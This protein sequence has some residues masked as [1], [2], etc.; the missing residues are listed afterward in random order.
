MRRVFLIAG[1][2]TAVA[3]ATPARAFVQSTS[4][5]GAGLHWPGNCLGVYYNERGSDDIN[6]DSDFDAFDKSL[7]AWNQVECSSFVVQ[8]AGKTNVEV[9][10]YQEEQ[11]PANVI[12]FREKN[13]PYSQRPVA[14]TSVTYSPNDGVIVDADIEMNG[15]DYSFTTNPADEPW[16]IDVQNTVTHELGHFL[17]LDHSDDPVST[18][19]SQAEPGE[20]TKRSLEQDDIDGACTLYPIEEGEE[21]LEIKRIDLFVYPTRGDEGGCSVGSTG[22]PGALL[23]ALILLLALVLRRR[24]KAVSHPEHQPKGLRAPACLALLLLLAQAV[25]GW[26]FYSTDLNARVHWEPEHCQIPYFIDIAGTDDIEGDAEFQLIHDAF[27]VWNDAECTPLEFQFAGYLAEPEMTVDF[28]NTVMFVAEGWTALADGMEEPPAGG[29]SKNWAAFTLITYDPQTGMLT[30]TDMVINLELFDFSDCEDDAEGDQYDFFY[31]VL[32]EIG[33]MVGLDHSDDPFAVMQS[34]AQTCDN[35]PPHMLTTDDLAG[36]CWFYGNQAWMEACEAASPREPWLD[37]P[38]T[39][40]SQP[41]MVP[42]EPSGEIIAAEGPGPEVAEFPPGD[43]APDCCC[44][45][46]DSPAV[47]G[48]IP[49]LLL[50]FFAIFFM[51]RKPDELKL[52]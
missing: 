51:I 19:V 6:D 4:S 34:A 9:T 12:L 41:E 14:F 8:F 11:S 28:R 15:E 7:T 45:V 29:V 26:H 47:P 36:L 20:V 3:F 35:D 2:A 30:D 46:L 31:T 49:V 23:L 27:Q 17:G 21:C 10:G 32:H 43:P 13:W 39:A 25:G 52:R 33:H 38:V 50:A 16:R 1:L 22:S 40:E 5:A 37:G 42:L 18:M 24:P 48:G 44:T